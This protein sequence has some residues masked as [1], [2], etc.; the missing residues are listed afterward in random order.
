MRATRDVHDVEVGVAG[1]LVAVLRDGVGD[2][3]RREEVVSS[4]EFELLD[5]WLYLLD[6]LIACCLRLSSL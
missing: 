5:R 3:D 6:H 4:A 1:L 2:D